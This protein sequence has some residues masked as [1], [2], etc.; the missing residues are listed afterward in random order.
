[1]LIRECRLTPSSS[2]NKRWLCN[3][4][5]YPLEYVVIDERSDQRKTVTMAY[6]EPTRYQIN[7][8]FGFCSKLSHDDFKNLIR[9]ELAHFIV[10]IKYGLDSSP[11]GPLFQK[12]CD[13]FSWDKNVSAA[14]WHGD[15]SQEES[16]I[17][18]LEEHLNN[19]IKKLLALSQSGGN[20][21][22]VAK[23]FAELYKAKSTSY[24]FD[25]RGE[26][27]FEIWEIES[28][29]RASVW[30]YGVVELM[31]NFPIKSVLAKFQDNSCIQIMG[32][33]ED[34]ESAMVFIEEVKIYLM[35][36]WSFFQKTYGAK[37]LDAK[38]T[39]TR[40]LCKQ[41]AVIF[42]IN[43]EPLISTS[44]TQA[45]NQT[46]AHFSVDQHRKLLEET[47][48]KVYP[49]LRTSRSSS[50]VNSAAEGWGKMAGNLFQ[51]RKGN[52]N[53]CD[54]YLLGPPS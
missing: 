24:Q 33:R 6:Y 25:E 47:F 29:K 39:F 49:H 4:I 11:H 45:Q 8:Y 54:N 18:P 2:Q 21:G 13:S 5:I 3:N 38:N 50:K 15:L 20:E 12:V 17:P 48:E 10:H 43:P 40:S 34:L 41:I 44:E 7:F 31:Q 16:N 35:D 23:K 53:S 52:L 26:I 42:K 36:Q 51:A 32:S 9:H 27:T 1:I 30:Q 22:E 28:Q 46:P 37:G 19:K 14:V